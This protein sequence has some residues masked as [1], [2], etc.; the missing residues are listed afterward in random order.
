MN[1]EHGRSPD[2]FEDEESSGPWSDLANVRG[3]LDRTER[4]GKM[5]DAFEVLSRA[6]ELNRSATDY[7]HELVRTNPERARLLANAIVKCDA[8]IRRDQKW[9]DEMA[10]QFHEVGGLR[11]FAEKEVRRGLEGYNHPSKDDTSYIARKASEKAAILESDLRQLE[12]RLSDSVMDMRRILIG[13]D[14]ERRGGVQG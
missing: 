7:I 13:I 1:F 6:V 8:K 2:L 11:A 9:I 14:E 12:S 5:G 3:D 10:G 4:F